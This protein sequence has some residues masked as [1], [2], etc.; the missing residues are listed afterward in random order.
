MFEIVCLSHLAWDSRLFQRPQQLMARLAGRGHR[1]HYFGCIGAKS[2]REFASR[3][4]KSG[5]SAPGTASSLRYQNLSYSPLTL[6]FEKF[7][8]AVA[9]KTIAG[10]MASDHQPRIAWIYHPGLLPL[11][12]ALKPDLI[13]YDV[14][15]RFAAFLASGRETQELEAQALAAANVIFTGGQSLHEAT[16][17]SLRDNDIDASGKIIQCF[18]SGVDLDHFAKA[19]LAETPVPADIASLPHPILG[20]FGAIDERM[21]FALL[22]TLA[23]QFSH[24]SVVLVGPVLSRPDATPQNLH[25]LGARTYAD[26]PCYLKAFDVCLLPFR[27]TELVAHISPTKTPEYLAGGR[28]VVSIPIPDVITEWSDVV[29]VADSPASFIDACQSALS[30]A[31]STKLAN[32]AKRAR[33]WDQIANEMDHAISGL[34]GPATSHA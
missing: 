34:A 23:K 31:D 26:L 20:Y 4:E 3:G 17:Q 25:L 22:D 29:A 19:S 8:R 33:T 6:R 2:L 28:P 30:S 24:G 9:T 21:D 14:M 5:I 11:A 12:E 7:R 16:L 13:V 32:A 27:A 10:L 15:D 1:V 18:P